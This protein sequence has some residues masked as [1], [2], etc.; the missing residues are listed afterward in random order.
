MAKGILFVISAPSGAG[1]STLSAGLLNEVPDLVYSISLT[2][3]SPRKGEVN[4][5]DYFFV[6]EPE[7]N[8]RKDAGEFI[9][10]AKVHGFWYG[11][12]KD[13]LENSLKSGKGVL[14]DIDVQ[15]G[16]QIRKLYPLAVLIFIAPPSLAELESRLRHR[17]QD[18]EL[19]I[20]KRM[21]NARQE[22]K[23]AGDYQYLVLNRDVSESVQKLK[24]VVLAERC[25]MDVLK[26]AHL[27]ESKIAQPKE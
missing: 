15:G 25:R 18:D 17:S 19:T 16:R 14:L 10:C 2:T 22:I 24:A 8:R 3:R 12:P 7:F 21:D 5:R 11:T 26:L 6:P 23:A 13:F 20:Q 9:E 1:K 4:G 27:E